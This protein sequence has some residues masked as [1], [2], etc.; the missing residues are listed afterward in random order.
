MDFLNTINIKSF[1]NFIR[2]WGDLYFGTDTKSAP[3]RMLIDTGSSLTWINKDVYKSKCVISGAKTG[4]KT[5]LTASF[6]Y[7][8]MKDRITG[9]L[10]E[11]TVSFGTDSSLIERQR[12][13]LI[14]E[15]KYPLVGIWREKHN[16]MGIIGLE[17]GKI[18]RGQIIKH[19]EMEVTGIIDNLLHKYS[20]PAR[21]I[22]INIS[23]PSESTLRYPPNS[24]K[25][26]AQGELHIGG[27]IKKVYEPNEPVR[28]SMGKVMADLSPGIFAL[29]MK[30][31]CKDEIVIEKC[32][33]LV[34]T[35]C[36]FTE[37]SAQVMSN[38][39]GAMKKANGRKTIVHWDNKVEK[40]YILSKD[41]DKLADLTLELEKGSI[42]LPPSA[43]VISSAIVKRWH[44]KAEDGRLYLSIQRSSGTTTNRPCLGL[45]FSEW[46]HLFPINEVF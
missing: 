41:K 31:K 6:Q 12:F 24:T 5:G 21:I 22:G 2:V 8:E 40:R 14:D 29:N 35:G 1:G 25:S 15:S 28:A 20:K 46:D 17:S 10:Y 30:I 43:Q 26:M 38:Y 37:V 36:I 11:D 13:A 45:P 9:E 42:T 44:S 16:I 18:T 27:Y 33:G 7:G 3:C 32:T 39:L 19:P 23:A 34:D 4:T